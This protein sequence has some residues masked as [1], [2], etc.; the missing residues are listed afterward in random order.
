[1]KLNQMIDHTLLKSDATK[2]QII[3]LCK[4]AIEHQ[5]YSVCVNSSWVSLCAKQCQNSGVHICSVVGFPL[6]AMHSDVMALEAKQAVKDGAD[7]IDMVLPIG[8]LKE[9]DYEEVQACIQKVVDASKP[10]RVKV[11]FETCLLNQ[12]E[13]K[14]ACELSI[15]AGA[16]FVKT[17]TG[18][19]KN[20]AT[21]DTVMFMKQCVKDLVQ[22][23]ASGGIRTL[24]DALTMLEAGADRLGCSASVAIIKEMKNIK[25]KN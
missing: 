22:V 7:E 18:F 12:E 11:I 4:E 13:I 21:K 24:K 19:S 10:A 5:F 15:D 23:K 6:G 20:G 3:Q 2:S 25:E 1:M 8:K 9:G 14:K 16:A 17:S